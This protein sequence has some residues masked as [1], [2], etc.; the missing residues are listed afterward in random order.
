MYEHLGAAFNVSRRFDGDDLPLNIGSGRDDDAIIDSHRKCRLR[1]D[2]IA[3]VIGFGGNRIFQSNGNPC[4]RWNDEFTG[5][6]VRALS[7]SWRDIILRLRLRR[8]LRL[9]ALLGQS[10]AGK[11]YQCKQN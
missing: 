10:E 5:A 1:V 9:S 8:Y 6:P 3:F 7:K 4:T 11:K 2:G